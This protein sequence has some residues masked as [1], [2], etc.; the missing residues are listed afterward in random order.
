MTFIATLRS[1][2]YLLHS[3]NMVTQPARVNRAR[4]D[5][6]RIGQEEPG[7]NSDEEESSE[8]MVEEEEEDEVAS[9]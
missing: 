3:M 6:R 5:A 1:R 9:P 7:F 4:K 2:S 8:E